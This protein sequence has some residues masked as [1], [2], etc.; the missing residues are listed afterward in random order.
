M[1]ETE[2]GLLSYPPSSREFLPF[3]KGYNKKKTLIMSK[4]NSLHESL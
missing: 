3:F 4:N 2:S 1:H